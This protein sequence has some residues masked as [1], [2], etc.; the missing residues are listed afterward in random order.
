MSAN[1]GIR[2][3]EGR[4]GRVVVVRL[5]PGADL[6]ESLKRV[7]TARG[8]RNGIILGGVASLRAAELR[9][10]GRYPEAF[11]IRD[12]D[13]VF[14]HL[15][16]PLELLSLS[17]NISEKEDGAI[18][19]HCHGVISAGT[20]DATAFGG[21]LLPGLEILSTAELAIVE[22]VGARLRR[23]HDEETEVLELFP[24]AG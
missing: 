17:G 19:V 23:L 7:A 13:R 21:H 4:L 8:I 18:E 15:D 12:P 3:A 1:D 2:V 6:M 24:E 10:V 20:P 22:V 16:G 11:P 9:N 5:P 14:T